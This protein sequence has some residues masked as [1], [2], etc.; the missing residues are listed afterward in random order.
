MKLKHFTLTDVFCELCYDFN[1][2]LAQFSAGLNHN[3]RGQ[4]STDVS[5]LASVTSSLGFASSLASFFSKK[6]NVAVLIG[7]TLL[8]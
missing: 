6:S 5:I 3:T 8:I 1:G 2:L 4:R 7:S